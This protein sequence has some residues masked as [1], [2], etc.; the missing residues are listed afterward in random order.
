[1]QS[2]NLDPHVTITV[3]HE[4]ATDSLKAYTFRKIAG[5][6]LD[7]PKIIEARAIL[8]VQGR[9]HRAEIILFCANHITI[10]ASSETADMYRSIDETIDKVARRMR[11]HKTR[12]LKQH[13]PPEEVRDALNRTL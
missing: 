8:D 3:R 6:H 2:A 10:D 4:Q 13:R 5:L 11:K 1:M 12:L 9:R 7:Y